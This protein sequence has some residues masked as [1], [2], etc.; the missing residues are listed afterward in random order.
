MG[1]SA[2]LNALITSNLLRLH[3]NTDQ[4][5]S[6]RYTSSG[7][8]QT[9]PQNKPPTISTE[10]VV[11]AFSPLHRAAFQEMVTDPILSLGMNIIVKKTQL[12]EEMSKLV[13]IEDEL[14]KLKDISSAGVLG[15]EPASVS[16]RRALLE[17]KMR[18]LAI[19][20][21]GIDRSLKEMVKRQQDYTTQFENRAAVAQRS[22]STVTA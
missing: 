17:E 12:D 14:V 3:T 21:E 15:S 22:R 1:D 9:L 20:I 10:L 11:S 19:K 16:K 18:D 7:M 4:F 8:Q 13:K 2:A 6:S 5:H